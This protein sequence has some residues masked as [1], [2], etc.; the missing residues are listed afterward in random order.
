[1]HVLKQIGPRIGLIAGLLTIAAFIQKLLPQVCRMVTSSQAFG[2]VF[3]LLLA[4]LLVPLPLWIWFLRRKANGI[5]GLR[6]YLPRDVSD[7]DMLADLRRRQ[8]RNAVFLGISHI[9]LHTYLERLGSHPTLYLEEIMVYFASDADGRLWEHDAFSTNMKASRL[10][11]SLAVT[12]AQARR[13]LKRLRRITFY[14][15]AHHSTFGGVMIRNSKGR[16]RVQFLV[17]YLPGRLTDTRD[18]LAIRMDRGS[19]DSINMISTYAD[20]LASIAQNAVSLGHIEPS[21]WD[22]SADEW[23]EFTSHCKAYKQS[24]EFLVDSFGIVPDCRVL[25]VGAGTGYPS[26]VLK[27]KLKPERLTVL[28]AS[29]QVLNKAKSIL[30]EYDVRYALVSVPTPLHERVIDLEAQF[31]FIILH[32]VL[33]NIASTQESLRSVARWCKR[34]LAPN[35]NVVIAAHNTAVK[36]QTDIFDPNVD[37]LRANLRNALER[38]GLGKFHDQRP[39]RRFE[40]EEVASAF[41]EAGFNLK[42]TKEKS[43]ALTMKDRIRMWSSPAVFQEAVQLSQ[44]EVATIVSIMKDVEEK[45]GSLATPDMTIAYWLFSNIP[46]L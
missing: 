21:L 10:R 37:A 31:D 32:L 14:Q 8:S 36:T 7:D 12:T 41:Y 4:I 27:D 5:S 38:R 26:K 24:M 42:E 35:G 44:L 25:D 30:G 13:A 20:S 45:V 17:N 16:C 29:P 19:K 33:P 43:Y 28:D 1:M 46:T 22:L 40:R 34:W 18:S 2:Y 11:V 39:K 3:A 6:I 15:A 23:A 9:H